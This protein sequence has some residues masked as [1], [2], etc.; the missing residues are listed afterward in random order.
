MIL[1]EQSQFCQHF[2]KRKES[3]PWSFPNQM[4]VITC[5]YEKEIPLKNKNIFRPNMFMRTFV[6]MNF[7]PPLLLSEES[8]G[9]KFLAEEW[10]APILRVRSIDLIR[11]YERLPTRTLMLAE[12][13]A[14]FQHRFRSKCYRHMFLNIPAT[15]NLGVIP[16]VFIPE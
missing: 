10:A 6:G 11:I 3:F 1:E 13:I 12:Y 16:F 7:N 2:S 9:R 8:F 15:K 4:Q 14:E 5:N